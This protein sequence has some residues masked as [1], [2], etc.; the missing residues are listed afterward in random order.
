MGNNVSSNFLASS[1][2]VGTAVTMAGAGI[3]LHRLGLTNDDGKKLLAKISQKVT[4]PAL[5]FTKIVYCKQDSSQDKCTSIFDMLDS[6]WMILFWP[7]YVVG[8]GL[9]VG[10]FVIRMTNTP[11]YHRPL[12]LACCAFA[13][14]TGL[15]I[16][17]LSVIHQNFSPSTELGRIDATLFLSIYLLLYPVLQWG[18]GGWLLM[19]DDSD[20]DGK[21]SEEGMKRID[22]GVLEDNSKDSIS[23][24]KEENETACDATAGVSVSYSQSS[25][26]AL[27][28][29]EPNYFENSRL[30]DN[31]HEER[32]IDYSNYADYTNAIE[33]KQ[34]QSTTEE[35]ENDEDSQ[36]LLLWSILR[37]GF[38]KAMQP[39]VIGALSGLLVAAI[40]PLRAILVDIDDRN[41]DAL[42]EFIFDGIYSVSTRTF[43]H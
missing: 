28:N 35:E 26:S 36:S 2:S 19:E 20:N 12:V 1:R 4:I 8:C 10:K 38:D 37:N 34:Q 21:I 33:Q 43:L 27:G 39:P 3:Y 25:S 23:L 29:V 42:L 18:I 31:Y 32:I 7:L 5:L 9:I 30:I 16:T 14:S 22:D 11:M 17:L 41:D 24:V 6:V 40:H 15:P 13:N